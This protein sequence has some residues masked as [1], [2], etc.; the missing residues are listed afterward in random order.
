[1]VNKLAFF[2][3]SAQINPGMDLFSRFLVFLLS[4][5]IYS[6]SERSYLVVT[7]CANCSGR[8]TTVEGMYSYCL[9]TF[10]PVRK[11]SHI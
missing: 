11:M 10:V 3:G 4:K 7:L 2:G 8:F 6:H 5:I 9:L 1:M